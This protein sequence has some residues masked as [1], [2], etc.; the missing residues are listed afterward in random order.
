[1]YSDVSNIRFVQVHDFSAC[2]F[3][4]FFFMLSIIHLILQKVTTD[5]GLPDLPSA[6]CC[7]KMTS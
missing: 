7:V 6:A 4:C 1:M 3:V 2:V 5:G